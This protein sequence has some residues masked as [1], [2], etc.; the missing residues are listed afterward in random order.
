M[1]FARS[2]AALVFLIGAGPVGAATAWDESLAGDFSGDGLAP[3]AVA[4]GLGSNVILG[5]TGDSGMGVDRDYFRFTVPDGAAL[6]GL[7][8]LSNTTVSGST[9]FIGLQAGPQLTVSPSGAGAAALLGFM[10]YGGDSVGQNLLPNL[11]SGLGGTLPGGTYSVWIQEIGGPVTYGFEFAITA[12]P[13]PG[14][15][16]LMAAGL[17]GLAGWRRRARR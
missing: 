3:T 13:E 15:G 9:S 17:L 4:M 14:M 6:T 8:V 16:A 1:A 7:V 5:S 10:H 12:I 11:A 2:M